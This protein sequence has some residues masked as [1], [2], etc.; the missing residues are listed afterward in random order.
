MFLNPTFFFDKFIERPRLFVYATAGNISL[1]ILFIYFNIDLVFHP[2]DLLAKSL[3]LTVYFILSYFL[4]F[5]WNEKF[6]TVFIGKMKE[7]LLNSNNKIFDELWADKEELESIYANLHDFGFIEIIDK[8]LEHKDKVIFSEIMLLDEKKPEKVKKPEHRVFKLK[9]GNIQTKH[10][11]D[12]LKQKVKDFS[13]DFL[14][15]FFKNTN[16]KATRN[17]IESSYSNR[18]S[19]PKRYKEIDECFEYKKKG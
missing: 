17:S 9:M 4:H 11:N 1:F 12:K 8:K 6:R 14:L 16:K 19:D 5:T 2:F 10:F 15:I 13:L 3:L 18:K 7:N